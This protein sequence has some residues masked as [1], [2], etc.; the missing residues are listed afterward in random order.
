MVASSAEEALDNIFEDLIL[1]PPTRSP[2]KVQNRQAARAVVRRA[3]KNRIEAD[4]LQEGVTL[5][6]NH[7]NEEVDFAITDGRVV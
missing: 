2:R 3:Y 5:Q 1:D 4:N 6:T 7:H